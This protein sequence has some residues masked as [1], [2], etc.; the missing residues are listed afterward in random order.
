MTN[1]PDTS[2][3]APM[4]HAVNPL[5]LAQPVAPP[6]ERVEELRY[7]GYGELGFWRDGKLLGFRRGVLIPAQRCFKCNEPSV[8]KPL[9]RKLTW[10][11]PLIYLTIFAGL[12]IYVIVALIVR[13]SAVVRV[14]L[15]SKHRN[16]QR[17]VV[18]VSAILILSIIPMLF[19]AVQV[20]NGAPYGILGLLLFIAGLFVYL[21]GGQVVTPKLIDEQIILVKGAGMPYLESFPPARA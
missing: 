13:K 20:T 4:A 11:H 8:G 18:A 1:R 16:Q 17:I 14:G 9:Q 2:E 19:V 21:I 3:S 7:A 12:I 10:H 5:P 15:C 6:T